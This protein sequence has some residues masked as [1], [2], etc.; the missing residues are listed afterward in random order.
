MAL[1][2]A[3]AACADGGDAGEAGAGKTEHEGGATGDG[4]SAAT[5][6]EGDG[7]N[8]EPNP[9]ECMKEC[10][11]CSD[12]FAYRCD[13][14][15]SCPASEPLFGAVFNCICV[16]SCA[17][18]CGPSLCQGEEP[19]AECTACI[20]RGCGEQVAACQADVR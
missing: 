3:L 19:S 13:P 6:D 15:N 11:T 18:P 8:D 20:E 17:E 16:D 14:E 2:A 5:R 4:G 10:V 7:D 1:I 9:P 12:V